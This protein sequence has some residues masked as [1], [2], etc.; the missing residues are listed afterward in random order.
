MSLQAHSFTIGVEEEY[1]V[2]DPETREL[3]QSTQLILPE[4]Q[5]T[6][7]ENVQ[8]EMILSQIE[9]ATP[10][11]HS[12][13]E[14][15][16]ELIRLRGGVITA[17]DH[18]DKKIAAAGTHAFSQWSEQTVTPKERYISLIETYQQMIREQVIFGC[19]VHIG[20]PDP[21]IAIQILNHARVWLSPIIALTANSPFWLGADTGYQDYRTGLW[22]TVPLAGPPPPFTSYADYRQTIDNMIET[23]S[24]DDATKIYWDLRPSERF[25]T[26]EFRV[27]D[28]AMTLEEAV[29]MAGLI[30][31]LVHT[32]YDHVMR[33]IPCPDF[34]TDQLRVMHWRA[35]R[36]GLSERLIDIQARRSMPARECINNMLEFIR[37]ALEVEGDWPLVANSVQRILNEGNGAE[38][39][40]RVYQSTGDFRA[41]VDYI[42]AET[43]NFPQPTRILTHQAV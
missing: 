37:P 40:Q 41:L 1:Q 10:V 12:L 24:I 4:A 2:I 27:M 7:G 22:W 30:R 35:A 28:V 15:Q 31:G 8:H 42:V 33:K 3:S 25:P 23:E 43:R 20:V 34:T 14:V 17:A 21:E 39:Q 26:L 6:L 9:I 32:C 36:Y 13:A 18:V 38:R 11:C 16:E 5:K 19:H 29:M